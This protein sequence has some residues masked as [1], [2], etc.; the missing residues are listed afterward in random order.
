MLSKEKL[1][2]KFSLIRRKKYFEVKEK[3]FRPILNTINKNAS[4]EEIQTLIYDIGKKYNFS[5]LRDY[6]KLIY[7]RF[8][9]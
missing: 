2:K 7:V 3:F 8:L 4:A 6:F 9:F 1:R 5:N